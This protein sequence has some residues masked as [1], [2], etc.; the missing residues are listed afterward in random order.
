MKVSIRQVDKNIPLP[1]YKTAGAAASDCAVREDAI[2]P[3]HSTAYVPLNFALKPPPGHWVLMAARSSL[4]K[5]GLMLANSIG[6]FDEDFSG[7]EDE[8]VAVLLNF[9]NE[10]VA[11]K[12]GDRLTQIIF[13]PYDKVEWKEVDTLGNSTRGGFGTTGIQ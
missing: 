3:P 4:H 11:V 10:S 13:V 1:E 2:I 12:K 5:R 8:Y 6:V 7:D 9:T